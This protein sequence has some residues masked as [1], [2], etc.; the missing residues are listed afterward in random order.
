MNRLTG[1]N[2][3]LIGFMATG[4]SRVG[5]E[6][7]R[8]LK[9]P[10][11]DTD[12]W[13]EKSAGLR[14]S[15]IFSF[16]GEDVFR[17]LESAVIQQIV[18]RRHQVISLGGGAVLR[19]ENWQ[20][21]A[22]SG[23]TVCLTATLQTIIQRVQRKNDRPLLN[24]ESNE[25]LQEKINQML[26]QRWPHYQRADYFFESREQVSAHELALKIYHRLLEA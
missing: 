18:G 11:V 2:I 26:D 25:S 23:I 9:W 15:E 4:K 5:R 10:F 16:Q 21:I 20:A 7:A 22:T 8:L 19:E 17:D 3:Y 14:I 1:K 24:N 12:Q 13:V 6:L